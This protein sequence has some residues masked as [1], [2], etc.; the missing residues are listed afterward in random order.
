VLVPQV[1]ADG[2]ERDGVRLPE[3]AAPLATY[4]GW[5][6]RD[7]SIGA[8]DQRVAFEASFLPFPKTAADRAKSG[9]PRKSVAKRYTGRA[10]YLA[11][12]T[13]ALDDLIKQRWI[14]EEDRPAV[15]ARG[16]AEWD[17]AAK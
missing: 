11:R 6:L 5:N 3:Y 15:L 13:L 9:D 17:E 4:V 7:P 1:D 16:E 14:L 8:P 12:Y 2:N 10:D